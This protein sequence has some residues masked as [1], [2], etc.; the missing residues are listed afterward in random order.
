LAIGALAACLSAACKESQSD[1]PYTPFGVVSVA[2]PPQAAPIASGEP[3]VFAVQKAALAPLGAKQW[4]FNG[5]TLTAV[6]SLTF[7]QALEADFDNDGT[8][9]VVSWLT[10]DANGPKPAGAATKPPGELWLYPGGAPAADPTKL[11]E[12]PGFLPVLGCKPQTELTRTGPQTV[13]LRIDMRCEKPITGRMPST[14]LSVIAPRRDVPQVL[15]LRIANEETSKKTSEHLALQVSTL[16]RDQDGRDDIELNVSLE[17]A[18]GAPDPN[19]AALSFVWFDRKAGLSRDA[20]LPAKNFRD[21]AALEVVRSTGKN[22]SLKTV[23]RVDTLRKLFGALCAEGHVPTVF[24][25]DNNAL[26]CNVSSETLGQ[27]ATAE[28]RAW[29]AQ[30][31]WG[32]ALTALL[33]ANWYGGSIS[34]KTR[35]EL[36]A[37][38]EKALP[39]KAARVMAVSMSK[40]REGGS[41]PRYSPLAFD[42]EGLLIQHAEGVIRLGLTT[43]EENDASEEVDPWALTV[44]SP[45]GE[46]LMGVAYPCDRQTVTLL[47]SSDS[48]AAAPI[49][50]S[51]LAPRPGSCGGSGKIA[52]LPLR[53]IA[54]GIAGLR[55][56]LGGTEVGSPSSESIPLGSARSR[57]AEHAVIATELGLLV[58]HKSSA[59]LWRI[60][61]PGAHRLQECVIDDSASHVACVDKGRATLLTTAPAAVRPEP[62]PVEPPSPSQP[63][64]P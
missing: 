54:W 53:P 22:T 40:P 9:E 46:R 31:A 43:L 34:E 11:F 33:R 1:R 23:L 44:L 56:L 32:N 63:T 60:D 19:A 7:E 39:V 17:E 5:R 57:N 4:V 14:A 47:A 29:L 48:G 28:V 6:G 12:S 13:T 51:L 27:L 3:S 8:A 42:S 38:L 24:D 50:T 52:E 20:R 36:T 16:D 37:E 64:A 45:Q 41:I 61:N 25:Q 49:A 59:E 35:T 55:A 2:E 10:P 30:K 18:R 62:S 58:L 26:D 21:I 15:T